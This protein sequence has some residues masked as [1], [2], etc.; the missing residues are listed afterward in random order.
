MGALYYTKSETVLLTQDCATNISLSR[1]VRQSRT[2]GSRPTFYGKALYNTHPI[3]QKALEE[4]GSSTSMEIK[5]R[6]LVFIFTF[7][8]PLC[9]SSILPIDET[10]QGNKARVAYA[11]AK[12]VRKKSSNC[13][14]HK[15][16][17]AKLSHFDK[18]FDL[19]R[20]QTLE[21]VVNVF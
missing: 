2:T 16:N 6:P 14:N 9:F 21:H 19:H 7:L 8:L 13:I 1:L 18:L 17:S 20:V 3:R 15:Q 4:V 12:E 11:L 5:P 10:N